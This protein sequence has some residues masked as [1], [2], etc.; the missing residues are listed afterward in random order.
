MSRFSALRRIVLPVLFFLLVCFIVAVAAMMLFFIFYADFS[1][2]PIGNSVDYGALFI[3]IVFGVV[4]LV[5]LGT[6][7]RLIPDEAVLDTAEPLNSSR[8]FVVIP[9]C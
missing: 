3:L 2:E 9:F 7:R 6:W 5:L 1:D 4:A 8:P